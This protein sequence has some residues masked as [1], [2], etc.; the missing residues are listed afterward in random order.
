[1]PLISLQLLMHCNRTN[2]NYDNFY[3][4]G[5]KAS[6]ANPHIARNLMTNNL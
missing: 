6:L 1:M 5:V 4:R 3:T 2:D